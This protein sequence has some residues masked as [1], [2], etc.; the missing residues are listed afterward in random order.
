MSVLTYKEKTMPQR[1]IHETVDLIVFGKPYSAIHKQK[2]AA[3]KW[4][5]QRREKKQLTKRKAA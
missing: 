1:W 5:K 3:W 4:L 2:D